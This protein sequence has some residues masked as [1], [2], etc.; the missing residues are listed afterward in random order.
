MKRCPSCGRTYSDPALN[1]CLQD[2]AV[3]EQQMVSTFGNEETVVMGQ[4]PSTNPGASP[5][6]SQP[7]N[8]PPPT[9]A[10][11]TP[12]STLPR[13][14][15]SRAWLWILL[16]FFAFCIIGV[17]GFVSFLIYVGMK[18]EE[19]EAANRAK[20]SSNNLTR[21]NTNR[22][23]SNTG[24][25][26]TTL[27][28]DDGDSLADF[29]KWETGDLKYGKVT[30][31]DGKL[32]VASLKANT[33]CV[34][35]AN[36]LLTNDVTTRLTVKNESKASTNLGF[37]L[38]VG[39]SSIQALLRDYAFLIRT[40]GTPSYRIVSHGATIEKDVVRWT[41]SSSIHKG[42]S[43]NE[44]EV[45]DSGKKLSFYINGDL[46]NSI[47]DTYDDDHAVAGIYSGG[48]LPITFSDL[49]V[50]K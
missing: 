36:N 37:G 50:E 47:D 4:T 30:Y 34:I 25:N 13:K 10:A 49:E 31:D 28:S 26:K 27:N 33:F 2:G 41:A 23:P 3:L 46:V 35:P 7:N 11:P 18:I 48:A 6:S 42:D 17:V 21:P 29:S 16:T 39:G 12:Y 14:K 45:R 8:V 1:F 15:K 20:Y 5:Y 22:G 43:E 32:T 38:V 9:W 44:L 40:D 24:S 19:Q